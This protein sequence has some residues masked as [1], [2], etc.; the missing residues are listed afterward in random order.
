[1]SRAAMLSSIAVGALCVAVPMIA[2]AQQD[3]DNNSYSLDVVVVTAQKRAENVQDVPVSVTAFSGKTLEQAGVTDIRDLRRI[4]PNLNLTTSAQTTNTRVMIRGVGTAGN[5][6][7]E[8]S[9]ATFVDGVY[10]P[11]VGSLLAGLNDIA[12][13]EILRGPQGTL[14]GRNAS[15][16]AILLSTTDPKN[17]FGGEVTAQVGDYGRRRGSITVNLPAGEDLSF[18]LSV[19]GFES[20]GFGRNLLDGARLGRNDAVSVRGGMKWD[21]SPK[22]TWTLKGDY[23][24]LTGDGGNVTT[25]VAKT[26]TPQAAANW[27]VRLDPDGAGPLTGDLP[28][29]DSTYKWRVR[30]ESDGDLSDHQVG[31]SSNLVW[32]LGGDYQLKLT[33]GYR[34][35]ENSQYQASAMLVPLP[36]VDRLGTF[37]SKSHSE[38]LQL[39]SPQNLFGGKFGFISGLYY[40]TEDYEIGAVQNLYSDYCEVFIRNTATAARLAA[41]RAGAL[42]NAAI[43]DFNQTTTAYAAYVQGAYAVTDTI[44]L[45]GGIRYSKDKKTGF[46][47]A[48]TNNAM[49]GQAAE[50]TALA[51]QASKVTYR[52]NASWRPANGVMLFASHATGFKS[53]GFDAGAGTTAAVGAANRTFKPE[54]TENTELGVKSEFLDRRVMLNATLFRTDITEYQFRSYDGLQFRVRNNGDIRQQGL[55]F[56]AVARPIKPLTFT[57]SAAYLDSQYLKFQGAPA[58]PALS[59][60]QDLTGQRLPFSP[61]WQGA[62]SAQYEGNLVAGLTWAARV[63]MGFTTDQNLGVSGDNNP[64]ANQ[65]GYSTFGARLALRG[66]E[67]TWELALSG[68]NLTNKAFC[69]GIYNQP[70]YAAYGLANA[71]TGGTVLRCTLNDPRTVA[72]ELRAKF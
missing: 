3:A 67:E 30:Q 34:D 33:S 51:L 65:K 13:V 60:V 70:T 53:G 6:A 23:Q 36:L 5:T 27:A 44:D 32:D 38:E 19:L 10:I 52:I 68:Q 64:D 37:A 35:W 57:L 4:T 39:S 9:V 8:P 54:L 29:L 48:I 50:A 22:L 47:D 63:D 62:A 14:F 46:F 55:E 71:A 1:M 12:S 18:R 11:R 28:L 17:E 41:C 20:D 56:D 40:Y 31:L 45:T 21:I 7:I 72:V 49:A 59:G 69:T 16:G 61:R 42:T 2:N 66:P 43:L 26:V 58:L 25:V 15:M 24:N